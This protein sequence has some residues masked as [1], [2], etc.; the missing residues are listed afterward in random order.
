M[1]KPVTGLT[2][3]ANQSPPWSL[4]AL[5]ADIAALSGAINDLGTYS[6][7][8]IDTG[9]VNAL[10]AAT[11][12]GITVSYGFGLLV[13]VKVANRTTSSTVTLN[14]NSL[15]AVPVKLVSGDNPAPAALLAGAIYAFFH[16]GTNFQLI[17][18]SPLAFVPGG[19]MFASAPSGGGTTLALG[20]AA[21]GYPLVLNASSSSGQSFGLEVNAGTNSSD[22]AL[23]VM[24]MPGLGGFRVRGDGA[25]LGRG[26]SSL[27]YCD[28]TPDQGQFIATLTGCTSAVTGQVNW[29]RNGQQV[30]LSIPFSIS[31]TSNSTTMTLTGLPAAIQPA[32]ATYYSPLTFMT[33][34]GSVI[35]TAFFQ[36]TAAS[37]TITC[38]PNAAGP[39]GWTNSGTKGVGFCTFSYSLV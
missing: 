4:T 13:Y 35:Y 38:W 36:I 39:G 34:A 22:L 14:I 32:T 20:G 12:S 17:G 27:L 31:G 24:T 2:T 28:M 30:T 9:S 23:N 6:N 18:L 21:G 16:D 19:Q 29:I 15:G 5:D 10:A 1:S 26:P 37:G 11:A 25:I 3:F 7:P 33:N 8:L